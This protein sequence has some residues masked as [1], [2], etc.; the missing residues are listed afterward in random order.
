MLIKSDAT[1]LKMTRCFFEIS[2]NG[3]PYYGWQQQVGQ[4]SVQEVIQ[5]N[6]KKIFQKEEIE[7]VGCGRTDKG[8]HAKQFFFHCDFTHE[9]NEDNLVYK[10][11]KML[12]ESISIATIFKVDSDL[13]A[14]FSATKRTYRYFIHQQKDPFL[15]E[16]STYFPHKVDIEN[17]NNACKAL[18]GKQDFSS[19]AKVHTDV[20][21]H[22]CSVYNAQWFTQGNQLVFEISADRFLRNMVRAIVGT[23]LDIGT[24]KLTSDNLSEIIAKKDRSAASKSVSANGLFLWKVEYDFK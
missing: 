8:V 23:M 18:L 6:L 11:N 12:P 10:L 22:I 24:N 16:F 13:H 20:K 3:S 15:S 7:I 1:L 19:F 21:T 17:M 9:F 14:R 5:K 4:V 2:Y